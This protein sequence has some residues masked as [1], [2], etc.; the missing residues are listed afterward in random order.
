M[1]ADGKSDI[2]IMDDSGEINILYGAVRTIDGIQ[3]HIFT[4]KL[5]ESGLGMR[6]SSAIRMDGGAF[7][8]TGLVLPIASTSTPNGVNQAMIDNL[9]YYQY[10]Y[11]SDN[12]GVV[13]SPEISQMLANT[14]A[15]AGSGNTDFSALANS[16]RGGTKRTFIRSSFAEGKGLK[17]AKSYKLLA[18]TP[19]DTMQ[20]GDKIRVELSLTNTS[21]KAFRD[22]VYLDSNDRKIF[23][24]DQNG[25][26]TVVRNGGVE[27]Q[28]PLKYLTE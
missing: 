28:H 4:K 17:V 21:S 10:N 23:L 1:D 15:I 3:Q 12:K 25:I 13:L 8:Y 20:T 22:V 16:D 9:I 19:R 5:I 14:V 11:Q 7:S 6:L 2:V 18:S 24:E 26:Y 27:T